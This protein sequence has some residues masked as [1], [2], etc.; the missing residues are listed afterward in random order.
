M[1][2]LFTFL[3]VALIGV[4]SLFA[5]A[6][7][8]GDAAFVAGWT[9]PVPSW[10]AA[11]PATKQVKKQAA[12]TLVTNFDATGADFDA[13]W[14]KIPGDGN[15]IGAEG[16]RIGLVESDHG[17]DDFS[18]AFKV[19]CDDNNIY[20]LLQYTD[21]DVTGEET[22]EVAW[23]PY[24]SINAPVLETL[25]QA[26]FTR[27]QQFGAYKAT[28][29]TTGFDAA[30]MVDGST[31]AVNWGGTND[32]LSA[33]L[34]L[35]NHTTV[36]SKTVKQII[37][38]G[39]ACLTGEAR[40]EFNQSIWKMI[41]EGRGISLDLK[42]NDKDGDD[43]MKADA[44]GTAPAE[45][46]WN[47]TNNDSY[48]LTA[49]AGNLSAPA[50]DPVSGDAA[51]VA[52]WAAPIP[53]WWAALPA[54]EPA[55]KQAKAAMV[56]NF[57]AAGCDFDAEWAKIKGEV[58]AL[59]NEGSRLGLVDSD[60]GATDFA[61]GFKALYDEANIYLLLQYNDDD[62]T[63]AETVE[64]AWAPYL[65]IDAPVIEALP[66][67][68]YTRYQQF[69]AYKATFKTTGFDAAMMVDGSTVAVN[70]GG[71]NDI[72]SAN[73][74]LD[75]HTEVGSK[76]VKQIITIGYAC[77]TGEARPEFNAEIWAMLNEGKGISLDMKVN[78]IDGDD[79]MK[80]DA[81][82]T[83][84]AEYWWNAINNDSYALTTY[85]GFLDTKG[86]TTSIAP[87]RT[88]ASIF[89]RTTYNQVQLNRTAN[90]SVYNTLG[91]QMKSLRNVNVVDLSNL[92]SGVYIIRANNEIKKFF[93]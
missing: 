82:G 55:R 29:K 86:S 41:N 72:L 21:D 7:D 93:R 65:K 78:D 58:N 2:N 9:A 15:S 59:G 17:A 66:Q 89:G 31:A 79:A 87:S 64:V 25:P 50:S 63:G 81:S 77:L 33:N 48:A 22:V 45:Y 36:G 23:A 28:F 12:T 57:D 43:A 52:D 4:T 18:G 53:S 51:F 84:P 24:D 80:A 73:L 76:T 85:A 92:R 54:E 74:Y 91:Q 27:Y 83:A 71:T 49:Y 61:G 20:I 40:P 35:D 13:E 8:E 46:W 90:V 47:T 69:G 34:Y 60:H 42:V 3:F 30:M 39:F 88:E 37:A 38:I 14:D 6:P 32:I 44:S 11:V 75:D 67:A 26:W 1:K 19:V 56:S 5:Q 10:W 62:V 16:S 68:W 70:W